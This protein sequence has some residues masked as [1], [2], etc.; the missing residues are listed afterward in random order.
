MTLGAIVWSCIATVLV[1]W[2]AIT[3]VAGSQNLP[4]LHGIASW[5][6]QC[7]LGRLLLLGAWGEIGWHLFCQRP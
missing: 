7:W 2:I 6:L 1:A 4:T 3:Q 5:F